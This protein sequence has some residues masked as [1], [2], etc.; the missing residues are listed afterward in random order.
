MTTGDANLLAEK[1]AIREVLDEYCLRL[2]LNPFT[3]WL[4][5]FTEDTVY[6]VFRRTLK[7]RE[8]VA[9]MLSQAP[10]GVHIGGPARIEVKGD[11]AETVQNYLFVADDRRYSN[12]GWYYRNLVKTG[13]GWKISYTRVKLQKQS[14]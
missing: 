7:G 13:R 3:D 14:D 2:E 8:E 12:Q 9:A 6:E 10:H 11:T 5:L 4:D 1:A